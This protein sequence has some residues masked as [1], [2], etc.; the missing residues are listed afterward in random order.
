MQLIL[1]V[2]PK[3]QPCISAA[4]PAFTGGNPLLIMQL[5]SGWWMRQSGMVHPQA[6]VSARTTP[7]CL[8]VTGHEPHPPIPLLTPP[9]LSLA[10]SF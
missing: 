1:Q 3:A 5:Y 8:V 10:T 4:N 9:T 6:H 2:K 7:A